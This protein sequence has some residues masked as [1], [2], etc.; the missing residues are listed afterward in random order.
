MNSKLITRKP[1][2]LEVW[3]IEDNEY[4]V[5]MVG[6]ALAALS[7]QLGFTLRNRQFLTES[8]FQSEFVILR[9]GTP[10]DLVIIDQMIKWADPALDLPQATEEVRREGYLRA[11]FRAF[12][13]IRG[14][15]P[16]IP[17]IFYSEIDEKSIQSEL[18]SYTMT[19]RRVSVLTKDA[20]G[21]RLSNEIRKLLS[22]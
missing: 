13:A 4:A 6:E 5:E 20:E 2:F 7:I 18:Q 19:T 10:P 8:N 3:H 16:D 1:G 22:P 17:V 9:K 11:G 14:A 12:E 21:R 15:W